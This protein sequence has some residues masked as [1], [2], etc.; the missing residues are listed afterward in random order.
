MA[1]GVEKKKK[2]GAMAKLL[3]ETCKGEMIKNFILRG[4][5]RPTIH[6]V[7]WQHISAAEKRPKETKWQTRENKRQQSCISNQLIE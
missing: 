1:V 3:P 5:E 7:R 4:P 2:K 6:A